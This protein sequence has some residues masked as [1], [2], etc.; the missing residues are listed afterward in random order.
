VRAARALLL[1]FGAIALG[2]S[3]IGLYAA[4][5][6][7]VT[8]RS[9]EIAIRISLGAARADV[10]KL[11]LRHG[12]ALVAVGLGIGIAAAVAL[13]P[14]LAHLLY[15]VSPRDPLALLLGPAAIGVVA[16]AA[17]GLPARRAA[18]VDPMTALR[19]E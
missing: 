3:A 7:A 1:G 10:S 17:I 5:A 2:L 15:G 12:L 4:L 9:R 18:R 8:Q 11:V 13:G 6:F 14:L 16:L 19:S